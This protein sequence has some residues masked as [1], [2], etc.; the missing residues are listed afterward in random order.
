[1]CFRENPASSANRGLEVGN[2]PQGSSRAEQERKRDLGKTFCMLSRYCDL[3]RGGEMR[4]AMR[5]LALSQSGGRCH[6]TLP[7]IGSLPSGVFQMDEGILASTLKHT[8]SRRRSQGLSHR[9]PVP[10]N[11]AWPGDQC[12]PQSACPISL[13]RNAHQSG[14]CWVGLRW[15]SLLQGGGS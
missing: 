10:S 14:L 8:P 7:G 9:E 11:A 4:P 1:M 3:P 6:G 13:M 5:S 12:P 2:G 15:E